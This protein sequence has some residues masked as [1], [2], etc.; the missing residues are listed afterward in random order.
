MRISAPGKNDNFSGLFFLEPEARLDGVFVVR[1]D[2][3]IHP[4]FLD[5]FSIRPDMDLRGSVRNMIDANGKFHRTSPK[6]DR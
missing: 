6:D 5:T 2:N 1:A 3:I 4:R